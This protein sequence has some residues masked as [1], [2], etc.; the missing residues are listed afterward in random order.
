MGFPR[1]GIVFDQDIAARGDIDRRVRRRQSRAIG[2]IVDVTAR[3]L[4]VVRGAFDVMAAHRVV[5]CGI[6]D[7]Q[8]IR[9]HVDRMR[10]AIDIAVFREIAIDDPNRAFLPLELSPKYSIVIAL[11]HAVANRDIS[12]FYAN[13]SAVPGCRME[14]L[15][16]NVL[17]RHPLVGIAGD[18][19]Q[20]LGDRRLP[21][22]A[23]VGI[24]FEAGVEDR[25]GALPL[26]RYTRGDLD[27]D[28]F[29]AARFSGNRV[30]IKP[31]IRRIGTLGD[32]DRI[33]ILRIF[34][35]IAQ[36]FV[37]FNIDFIRHYASCSL[38]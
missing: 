8:R 18:D 4:R 24:A 35:R 1:H 26:D 37:A 33:A 27:I 9:V 13:A 25:A 30:Q 31:S 22:N 17:D 6:L 5:N 38:S 36:F 14:I 21:H 7:N 19:E 34:C 23:S 10:I 16:G 29:A 11:K 20:G 28:G 3:N 15:E 12:R 2:A 32:N